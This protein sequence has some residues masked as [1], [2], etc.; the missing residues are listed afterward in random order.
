MPLLQYETQILS[1]GSITLPLLPEYRNRK[2]VVSVEEGKNR[3]A[4]Q[5]SDVSDKTPEQDFLDF[6]KELAMPAW[7]DDD[8]E[9]IKYERLKNKYQ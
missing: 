6:C 3:I 7:H 8:V 4:P 5:Y 1:D 2:V 9:R